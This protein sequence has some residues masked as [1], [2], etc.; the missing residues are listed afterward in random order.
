MRTKTL[1]LVAALSAAGLATALAQT[2]YSLN[3]VGYVNSTIPASTVANGFTILCN[4]LNNGG[5]TLNEILPP[6][7]MTPGM[8]VYQYFNSSWK[9]ANLVDSVG[10]GIPADFIWS[11]NLTLNPGEGFWF[12]NAAGGGTT[13][14]TFVG[15]VQQGNTTNDVPSGFALRGSKVPQAL[16]LWD[17]NT[18]LHGTND[19]KYPATMGQTVIY[20]FR[21][22][23]Y[24]ICSYRDDGTGN[25]V[26][27]QNP[28][29]QV[30]EGFWAK[31]TSAQEWV[32]DFTV[33]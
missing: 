3:V 31:E 11:T 17:P 15:E 26:W 21:N 33:Q 7:Q 9:I 16:I 18:A 28:I 12:K 22:G 2:V 20:L 14:V 19:L 27:S 4:P 8:R 10:G 25:P 32:R 13:N 6:A 24:R 5:N 23:A 30:G 1:L 29:P